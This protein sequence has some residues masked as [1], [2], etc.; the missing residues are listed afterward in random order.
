MGLSRPRCRRDVSQW[1]RRLVCSYLA[2]VAAFGPPNMRT[3][4]FALPTRTAPVD[5]SEPTT[6]ARVDRSELDRFIRENHVDGE[7]S[8][9]LRKEGPKIQAAVMDRGSCAETLN[10][11][12]TIM[13]RIKKARAELGLKNNVPRRY[14]K[15]PRIELE[16]KGQKVKRALI[17]QLMES[18]DAWVDAGFPRWA[19]LKKQDMKGPAK[20]GQFIEGLEVHNVVKRPSRP[21][22]FFGEKTDV[23]LRWRHDV[24][25]LRVGDKVQGTVTRVDDSIKGIWLDVGVL[26]DGFMLYGQTWGKFK[27]VDVQPGMEMKCYVK[28]IDENTGQFGLTMKHPLLGVEDD[29]GTEENSW[30][31]RGMITNGQAYRGKVVGLTRFGGAWLDIGERRQALLHQEDTHFT[32]ANGSVLK[33]GDVLEVWVKRTRF[34]EQGDPLVQVTMKRPSRDF[35]SLFPGKR[36]K[37]R[38]VSMTKE[39]EVFIDIGLA[40]DCIVKENDTPIKWK[41]GKRKLTVNENTKVYIKTISRERRSATL[42]FSAK[43]ADLMFQRWVEELKEKHRQTMAS[44][45]ASDGLQVREALHNSEE[46]DPWEDRD[47]FEAHLD[48]DE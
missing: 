28:D 48:D 42:T 19:I 46:S 18:G 24:K 17:M 47:F 34:E 40:S 1:P 43:K 26:K 7:A 31:S 6:T 44:R 23:Y 14:G 45:M 20:K 3:I 39:G 37:G 10:P 25:L 30:L 5:K 8:R 16:G 41:L 21:S 22:E 9:L 13:G 33:I 35:N 15:L 4:N 2:W 38:V 36:V 29:D 11:S 27:D 32:N 12:S